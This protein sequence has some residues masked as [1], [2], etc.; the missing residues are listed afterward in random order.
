MWEVIVKLPVMCGL[1]SFVFVFM[2]WV[3]YPEWFC[4]Y[5]VSK[6][7]AAKSLLGTDLCSKN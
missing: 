5:A 4:L 6:F 3:Y 2:C 7:I 1:V